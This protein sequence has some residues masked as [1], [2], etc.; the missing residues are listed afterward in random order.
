MIALVDCN[1]FYVSCERLFNPSLEN[2]PC[3]VASNNDGMAIARSN[4]VKAL[5]IKMG[6]PIFMI[7]DLIKKHNIKIYSSNY[8][9]YADV[10]SRV[11]NTLK[12][13]T[14]N[15]EIYSIDECFLN[16]EGFHLIDFEK[17]IQDMRKFTIQATGIP[18]S[19]GVANT[20]TLAKLSNKIAKKN[21][22]VL[23]LKDD[24]DVKQALKDFDI[25]D[26]WGIGRQYSKKLNGYGIK[27]ALELRNCTD[28]FIK[29]HLSVVGLRLVKELRGEPC[30]GLEEV[31]PRKKG[32]CTSRSF[33]KNVERY[34]ELKEAVSTYAATVSGK[35]RKDNSCANLL[36]VFI[37]TNPFKEGIAQYS[38]SKTVKLPVPTNN[39]TELIH[40]SLMALKII[41]KNGYL[42]N[43]A[44]II[45]TG[46]VPSDQIQTNMFDS[47]DREKLK[48]VDKVFDQLNKTWGRG[49]VRVASEGIVKK[50]S[51]KRGLLSP[52]YTSKWEDIITAKC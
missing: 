39:T 1:N 38:A 37:H 9:L 16:F 18:V 36:T 41:F 40:H 19:V 48:K 25:S 32:I 31:V 12:Q 15:I 49:T 26:L 28:D 34:E 27:T 50:W 52:D 14:P 17:Y 46:I 47:T 7:Q 8:T 5:G 44:G 23:I 13:F 43:K 42:Y 35:L 30:I 2:Q 33:G 10:S 51:M 3:I 45:V 24:S 4:E 29:K 21:N 11:H 20:K 22:G 6:T